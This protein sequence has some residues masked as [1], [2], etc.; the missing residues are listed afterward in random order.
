M[1]VDYAE[2][3]ETCRMLN[4]DLLRLSVVNKNHEK[5]IEQQHEYIDSLEKNRDRELKT[6][7][8]KVNLV[9]IHRLHLL[10]SIRLY[11]S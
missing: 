2:I 8:E 1:K 3:E 9:C 10:L 6:I 11:G 7:A 5:N 4:A